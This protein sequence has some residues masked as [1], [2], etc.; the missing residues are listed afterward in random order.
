MK[1][2]LA[3]RIGLLLIGFLLIYIYA[4]WDSWFNPPHQSIGGNDGMSIPVDLVFN[5]CW[6][7][8]WCLLIFIELLVSFFTS[9]NKEYRT[10]NMLLIVGGII[11]L[12]TY[13]FN[14]K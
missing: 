5:I 13:I 6:M 2:Y 12:A 10:T 3:V 7:A 8:I 1:K 11:L 4:H 9:R 14:I